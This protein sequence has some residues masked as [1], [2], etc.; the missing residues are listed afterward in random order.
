MTVVGH[1]GGCP[2]YITYFALVPKD[3]VAVIVLTNAGDGPAG[4]MAMNVLGS[5]SGA[6]GAAGSPPEEET[7]DL[8]AYEG[9]YD[10]RPWGG[11]VA[12][13]QW[14]DE[15]VAINIPSDDLK[16]ASIKLKHDDGDTFLRLTDDGETREPWVFEMDE[17][18]KAQ[19]IFR[20][21]IY[22]NRID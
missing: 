9:N 20:H 19:R 6:L 18:G 8:S 4:D 13:R 2:G 15:L 1:G 3:K 22:F 10:V 11:E 17:S 14:G 12:I 21:S 7:P 16:E 5:I